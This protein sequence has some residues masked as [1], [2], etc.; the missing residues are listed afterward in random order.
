MKVDFSEGRLRTYTDE[1]MLLQIME[2][3]DIAGRVLPP[4]HQ[5]L[6]LYAKRVLER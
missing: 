6:R 5:A 3:Q 4:R 1:G 2:A